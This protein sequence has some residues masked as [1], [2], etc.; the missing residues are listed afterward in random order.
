[1]L[2][3]WYDRSML[4]SFEPYTRQKD[5]PL[6]ITRLRGGYV[7]TSDP[8]RDATHSKKLRQERPHKSQSATDP[9]ETLRFNTVAKSDLVEFVILARIHDLTHTAVVRSMAKAS[10]RLVKFPA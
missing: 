1:M 5:L 9:F 7:R 4:R 6:Q 3:P 10:R 2:D 8:F